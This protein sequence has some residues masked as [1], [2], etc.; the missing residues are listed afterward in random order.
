MTDGFNFLIDIVAK[1]TLVVTVCLGGLIL[2][3]RS[4]ASARHVLL[5]AGM[6]ALMALPVLEI[7]L[8]RW[9]VPGFW[10]RSVEVSSAPA[11]EYSESAAPSSP[12]HPALPMAAI[13]WALGTAVLAVRIASGLRTMCL[14]RRDSLQP[15][16]ELRSRVDA[17][18]DHRPLE[19][20]LGPSGRSPMTWGWRR[21]VLLMPAEAESWPHDQLRS[22]V[23]HELSH[24][25][26]ADWLTQTMAR[27]GCALFW[28]HPGVWLIARRMEAESEHAADDRVLTMGC[29]PEDYAQHLVEVA[30]S[31]QFG[32]TSLGVAMARKAPIRDR[33]DAVLASGRNRRPIAQRTKIALFVAISA[34]AAA[35]AAAGP[36]VEIHAVPAQGPPAPVGPAVAISAHRV[37]LTD[38]QASDNAQTASWDG[39]NDDASRNDR[40]ATDCKKSSTDSAAADDGGDQSSTDSSDSTPTKADLRF[41]SA[42]ETHRLQASLNRASEE[43]GHIRINGVEVSSSADFQAAV[44]EAAREIDKAQKQVRT[45]MRS[46]SVHSFDQA[47]PEV[48][49][50]V[51]AIRVDVPN[52]HLEIPAIHLHLPGVHV[53]VPAVKVDVPDQSGQ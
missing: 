6:A 48:K 34:L 26:R 18:T 45:E 35:V 36:R 19:L 10:V 38:N 8:P 14:A 13:V 31:V 44:Q 30:R 39:S 28:F 9:Q 11:T 25:E 51:P 20:I 50:D 4:S 21:P 32:R 12:S 22:V 29:P 3:R 1:S 46:V 42:N 15:T 43:A 23:L 27:L 16:E 53:H 52:V 5:V 24:I 37:D 40:A 49:V 47:T 33:L 7:G 17:L 41:L 2:M